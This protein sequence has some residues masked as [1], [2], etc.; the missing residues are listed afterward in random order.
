[1]LLDCEHK[2]LEVESVQLDRSNPRI[3]RFL[4]HQDEVTAEDVAMAL[5]VASPESESGG[6]T[7][8]HSLR[9]S[10][11]TNGGIIQPI[12]VNES[13]EG[14]FT[15]IEGNTRVAI[16]REL[17]EDDPGKWTE[18]PSVV[19]QDLPPEE[20]D[21]IRLQ[22]HLIGPRQWDPYSKAKYLHYLRNEEHMPYSTLVDY[23]GGRSHEVRQL[24]RAYVE[25][26][27]HYRP[28]IDEDADFDE[29]R[30]S[31]FRELQNSRIQDGIK[32]AKYGLDD[33]ADWVHKGKIDPT[34][35]MR[36]LPQVLEHDIARETFLESDLREAVKYV[37]I[38]NTDNLINS[39]DLIT[40]CAALRR[41]VQS[42]PLAE[43]ERLKENPDSDLA[44]ELILV[45]NVLKKSCN[46]IFGT[47]SEEDG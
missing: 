40:L 6:G 7:T 23:C 11:R 12:I 26:E 21:A 33:F 10:I 14:T 31:A 5:G 22:A 43:A 29:K 46:T 15:V 9:E 37:E 4:A 36:K 41:K 35:L 2:I 32:K 3:A 38:P 30:F 17:E 19:Y 18:I 34:H 47:D 1:M 39:L 42:M 20:I 25:M 28:L 16:Y 13:P 24:I 45:R 44:T 8:F 27:K